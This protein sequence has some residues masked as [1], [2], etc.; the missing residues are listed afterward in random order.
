MVLITRCLLNSSSSGPR[1]Q[2]VEIILDHAAP[3]TVPPKLIIN[4]F[5]QIELYEPKTRD[6]VP[7]YR[8][9]SLTT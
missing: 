3:T 5:L 1:F 2:H 4:L 8:D 9:F 7:L 6:F